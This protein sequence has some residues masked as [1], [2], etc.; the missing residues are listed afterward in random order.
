LT[1]SRI[2]I[3]RTKHERRRFESYV[4]RWRRPFGSAF[5]EK[6]PQDVQLELLRQGEESIKGTIAIAAAA[7]QRAA[8][9]M[10]VCGAGGVG[11]LAASTTLI[12]GAHPDLR[13]ICAATV[14]AFGFLLASVMCAFAIA[15]TDFFIPG[16]NPARLLDSSGVDERAS[17]A[18]IEAGPVSARPFSRPQLPADRRQSA[19]RFA[20]NLR[21]H[22]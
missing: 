11:L 18:R 7:D 12:A 5:W 20:C 22:R 13:L 3:I 2:V 9:T 15:P 4:P 21:V 10:G 8:T 17:L 14:T 16:F 1:N 6:I 19:A